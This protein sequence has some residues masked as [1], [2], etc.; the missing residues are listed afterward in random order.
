MEH[1]RAIVV[2][3]GVTGCSILYHL[4]KSGW[5]DV[6][7][8]ERSELT[9]G[10][11]WHAAGNLFALTSPSSVQKMHVYSIRMY[12][13]LEREIGHE[14]GY[15]PTGGMHLACSKEERISL[16]N[17]R[18]RARRNGVDAEWISLDEAK[19]RA[20]VL[21][22]GG[23]EGVLWEPTKGHVD[24]SSATNAYAT[25]ARNYGAS[26]RRH[27]P[28]LETNQTPDGGW[29]V[30]TGSSTIK[31]DVVINAAGLW[32]REVGALAGISFPLLP[33]EHHYLLTESIPEIAAMENE[34]PTIGDSENAYYSRQ[35]G[36]GLL[37]GA[38]E[39]TCHLWA[40]K[41]TPLDFGH[42]LLPDD[43]QRME[44]NF[45]LA[46]E[47]MPCL[48][49]AGIKSVINGPMIFSPDLGPMIGPHPA[50]R[51]YFC[52]V[53]VMTGFNQAGGI[54]RILADWIIEGEP[55]LDINVWDVAR[56]G[57]WA[58]R[59]FTR[60]RTLYFYEHRDDRVYPHQEYDAGRPV[61]T[62]PIHDLLASKGVVFGMSNG[63]ENPL[64]QARPGD[65]T[66]DIYSF[67]RGN[68]WD[69]VGE[70][71]LR[72]R[73]SVSLFEV[74]TFA[75][76]FVSGAGAEAALDHVLAGRIPKAVGRTALSPMLS[77]K[78]RIIGDFT[79]TRLGEDSFLML[80]AGS[81]QGI[82]NR[83]F[84]ENLD[85]G[86]VVF[87]NRSDHWT[88]LQIAGPNARQLLQRIAGE[89]VSNEAFPFLSGRKMELEGA[90]QAVVVRVSFTGELGYE[91]YTPSMY[92]RGLFTALMKAGE[93]L[94]LG[95]AGERALMN[96]RL[97][98]S[99]PSWGAELSPDYT[100]MEP[101]IDR[102][103]RF[104]KCD[105]IGRDAVMV[106][107]EKGLTEKLATFAVE[108]D[109]A[110][111]SG[112][113]PIF[114]NGEYVGYTSSGGYGYSIGTSIAL[115][116]IHPDL[117]EDGATFEIEINGRN[118]TARQSVAPLYDPQGIHMRA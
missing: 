107:R 111:C 68:W 1:F 19:R 75:K 85:G 110:D 36:D 83:W 101:G 98:K 81:M 95:L 13:E 14:I 96:L 33:V 21:N 57:P 12:E 41:G 114:Y 27:T 92:Q 100:P 113:E 49:R 38:Y 47:R 44:R 22:T 10:S 24:P 29:E 91:I 93:D 117:H 5:K 82:H 67:N 70:E 59:N 40:E 37:L 89:D 18:A 63:W 7:L 42:E 86:D 17:A 25:M 64:W 39:D 56:F 34:L 50:L 20:P 23:L 15:H 116:F 73:E 104:D 26:I 58:G 43:V 6:L 74:S 97:E 109:N 118:H 78:G 87:E 46:I 2:G 28:V 48:E 16:A 106:A 90:P 84:R 112:G 108:A 45:Q 103:V 102:F 55:E 99:F 61:R 71:C 54:G 76:Y 4:A 32:A 35:E 94:G 11:T 115:G 65:E 9:S 60:A 79:V 31:A 51:N 80:G 77:T 105:F 88:G 69:A 53:G 72:T 66:F 30:V 52:A 62:F 8:L 3:G